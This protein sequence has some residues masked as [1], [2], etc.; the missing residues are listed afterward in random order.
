MRKDVGSGFENVLNSFMEEM[1]N[2]VIYGEAV[3]G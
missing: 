1:M 2:R 3:G